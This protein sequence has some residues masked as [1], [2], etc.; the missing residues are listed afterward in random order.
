LPLDCEIKFTKLNKLKFRENKSVNCYILNPVYGGENW[1]LQK[2]DQIYRKSC[3]MWCWRRME[4]FIWADLER[5][6]ELL[7]TAKEESNITQK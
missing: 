5:N 7:H 1:A 3:E 4:K 2:V 6:K